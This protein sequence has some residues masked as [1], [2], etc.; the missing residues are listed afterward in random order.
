MSLSDLNSYPIPLFLFSLPRSGSTLCQRIL[1]AHPEV[2]TVNE[3]HILLP[4]LYANKD[5]D[6]RSTYSHFYVAHAVRD[7]CSCLPNGEEDYFAEMHNFVLRLY[8]KAIS[9]EAKYF[10]DKTPKYHFIAEDIVHLFPEGKFIFL[11]RNPLSILSSIIE[12]WGDGEWNVF[13]FKVD[14]YDGLDHLIKTNA[15]YADRSCAIRFEDVILK[16]IDTFQKLFSYLEISF[17]P[18]VLTRFSEVHF[19]GRVSDPNSRLSEYQVIQQSPLEKWRTVLNNPLRKAWCQNYLHWIGQERLAIMGYDL[20]CLLAELE[21]MHLSRHSI[22]RD[23]YR[24]PL[25]QAY[26]LFEFQLMKQKYLAWRNG[27]RVYMH[28]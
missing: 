3:P 9:H 11:W 17:D 27:Q 26:H 2:A 22:T 1:G 5:Y 12:T 23:A 14:L 18:Q 6:V 24:I 19:N 25:G 20:N 8:T 21:T 28:N 7:F 13:H 10:L 16:P 4:M 15:K